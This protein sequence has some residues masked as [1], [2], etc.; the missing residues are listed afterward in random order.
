VLTEDDN[1]YVCISNTN[2]ANTGV[3][4]PAVGYDIRSTI[5]PYGTGASII[6]TVDG[7]GD[8]DGYQWKYMYSIES[9][10]KIKFL[11]NNWMPVSTD[12]TVATNAS[13][14]SIENVLVTSGGSGY[15]SAVGTIQ[16]VTSNTVLVLDTTGTS[17]ADNYYN[18]YSVYISGGTGVGQIKE[19]V[20]YT[21][22][23]RSLTTNSAF[24][25]PPDTSSTYLVSPTITFDGDGHDRP[26]ATKAVAFCNVGIPGY[27]GTINRVTM[28]NSG[29][30]Y[31]H[32]NVTISSNSGHGSAATAAPIISPRY[33]HGANSVSQLQAHNVMIAVQIKGQEEG[34]NFPVAQD[35]RVLGILKDPVY[36]NGV[37]ATATAL[38]Q[39]TRLTLASVS[40][41]GKFTK[42]EM[43]TGTTTAAKARIVSF[44][45]TNSANTAGV[46]R[47]TYADRRF[48]NGE[49]ITGST[50][51]VT[52]VINSIVTG[53][54]KPHRGEVMYIENRIPIT[55]A[56]DQTEDLKIIVNF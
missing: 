55:R 8:P 25:T 41:S 21:G 33:G 36:A 32:A 4:D 47:I 10:E 46:L 22:S 7:N 43:I 11:T 17:S 48:S 14:G 28:I 31:S 9:G 49:T 26:S 45:N 35:F 51:S 56:V 12:T 53:D 3:D 37:A 50:S 39:T 15:N 34:N 5:K 2:L 54:L 19:I 1:V 13:N 38:D 42:D 30:N 16:T 52:G 44:A 18:G 23:T 29:K 27:S 20:D 6:T 40:S 24:T